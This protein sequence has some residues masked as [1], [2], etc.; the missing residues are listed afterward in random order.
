MGACTSRRYRSQNVVVINDPRRL[1]REGNPEDFPPQFP[2]YWVTGDCPQPFHNIVE[3][4]TEEV[5]HVQDSNWNN[6]DRLG[7]DGLLFAQVML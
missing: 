4:G 7:Y 3:C 2:E 5:T 1:S 6:D